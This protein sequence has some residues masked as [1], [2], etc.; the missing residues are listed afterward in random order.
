MH[1]YQYWTIPNVNQSYD[2][3]IYTWHQKQGRTYLSYDV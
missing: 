1:T 3:S 2:T